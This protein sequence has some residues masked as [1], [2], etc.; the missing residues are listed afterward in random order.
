MVVAHLGPIPI[1][2]LVL[3]VPALASAA[4]AGTWWLRRHMR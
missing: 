4:T 1:E 2:E 3:L